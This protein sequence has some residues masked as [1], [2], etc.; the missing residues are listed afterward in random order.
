VSPLPKLAEAAWIDAHENLIPCGPT[1]VGKSWLASALGHK[2]CRD[3]RS[4]L[5]QRILK[6]FADLT[7]ARGGGRYARIQR[8]LGGV[9]LLILDDWGLEPLDAAARHGLLEFLEERYDEPSFT[10]LRNVVATPLLLVSA[11]N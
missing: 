6:L 10:A 4:V 2:A 9:Q 3:N 1:G 11:S 7:L 5:Y 8:A